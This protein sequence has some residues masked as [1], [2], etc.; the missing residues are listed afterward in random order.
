MNHCR[1][2]QHPPRLSEHNLELNER[3]PVTLFAYRKLAGDIHSPD[4]GA[5]IYWH[6]RESEGEPWV[7]L[8]IKST[9]GV[10]NTIRYCQDAVLWQA[11][12]THNCPPDPNFTPVANYAQLARINREE[13]PL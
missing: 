2:E 6:I 5:G 8:V 7:F 9:S 1:T 4:L 12:T 10:V 11:S 13:Q 3:C